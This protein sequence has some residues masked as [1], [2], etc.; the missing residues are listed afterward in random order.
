MGLIQEVEKLNNRLEEEENK[1]SKKTKKFR[2]PFGKKVSKSQ[3]KK[4]YVTL[5]K[6]NENSKAVFKKVRIDD[7]TFMDEGIP[8]LASAGHVWQEGRKNNPLI[9]CGSFSVKPINAEDLYKKS[10]EDG[11]NVVGYRLLMNKMKL[12]AVEAK[13]QIGG[14]MKWIFGALILGV[15]GYAMMTGGGV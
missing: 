12:S 14:M 2:Y 4:N 8:K 13:K 10:L 5:L 6:L 3:K 11:S 7:Q 15:I 1:T 9:I